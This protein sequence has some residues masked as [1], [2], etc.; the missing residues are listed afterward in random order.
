MKLA[1][2]GKADRS[3]DREFAERVCEASTDVKGRR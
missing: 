2:E 1:T 3:I